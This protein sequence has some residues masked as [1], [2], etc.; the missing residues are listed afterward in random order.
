MNVTAKDLRTRAAEILSTVRRG[1]VVTITYRGREIGVISP[2]RGIVPRP[3]EPVGFGLWRG[4][5]DVRQV[6]RWLD[7]LRGERYRR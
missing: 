7:K 5:R 3:F 6:G 1:G 4:R 2:V